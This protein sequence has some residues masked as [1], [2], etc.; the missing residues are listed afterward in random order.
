[1]RA[2]SHVLP[3]QHGHEGVILLLVA[4]GEAPIDH[5]VDVVWLRGAPYHGIEPMMGMFVAQV[6]EE[7]GEVR[8]GVDRARLGGAGVGRRG[9]AR[10]A[11]VCPRAGVLR[12]AR[13]A[14]EESSVEIE[15]EEL[16]QGGGGGEGR[17]GR[18]CC[19][20]VGG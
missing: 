13:A 1:V 14:H 2:Q 17:G 10:A 9:R 4:D 6:E 8:A 15:D 7:G 3:R 19:A 11:L 18:V 5:V 20:E 16:A 12:R